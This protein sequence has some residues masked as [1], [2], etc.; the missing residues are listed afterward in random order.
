MRRWKSVPAGV[1]YMLLATLLF[2]MMK[3]CVKMVPQIPSV[4]IILFRSVISFIISFIGIKAA[5]I[6]PWGNN[7]PMLILRGVCGSFSLLLYFLLIQQIPLA[8]TYTLLYLA[9]VFTTI[10]GIYFVKEKVF[11]MQWVFFALSM[12]GVLM[13]TG[14]D[15][16]VEPIHLLIGLASSL[17]SGVAYNVIRKL[18]TS[19]HPLVIILYFPLVTIPIAGVYSIFIWEQPVGWEWFWLIM[20]GLFTQFAQYFMTKAYQQEELSIISSLSYLGIVYGLG[21]GFLFGETFNLLTYIG[22]ACVVM[23]VVS[24]IWWKK[25][26][27]V[28]KR[29]R[30]IV[31]S[32]Q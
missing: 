21:F 5:G 22:M 26:G 23:G 32:S 28:L 29:R 9:P 3:V 27:E 25:K 13:V 6:S 7:K 8:T 31:K 30:S 4:E 17:G 24:N 18:K 2:A 11:S 10:L 15:I 19:E 16:R 1:K 20:V 14:F 12:L